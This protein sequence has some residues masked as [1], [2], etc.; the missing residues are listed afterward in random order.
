MRAK[1][2]ALVLLAGTVLILGASG[3]NA[4]R[5]EASPGPGQA[6]VE[7][8]G[9][10][11][12]YVCRDGRAG[13]YEAF[14]D[15]CRL[16][17]GRLMSVFYAGYDHVSLPTARWPKGGRIDYSVS[18]DEGRTWSA[19]RVLYDGPDDDRDPSIVELPS[20]KLL[21]NFFSLRRKAGPDG[22]AG[23][24]DGL[25]TWLVE[26]SDKGKTWS[27][28]RRVSADYYCSS[29]VRVLPDGRLILGLYRQEGEKAWGAVTVSSDEG[30]TW[31]PAVD[32]PNGGFKLDAETDVIALSDGRLLAVQRE[33]G[34]TMCSSFSS[35]GGRTWSVSRAMGFPGH[36]PYL[37]RT[38]AGI[39]VL[40]H[41]LP[42]TSLHYSFDE[43][44][45]WSG[46]VLV[47]DCVGAYPS[48]VELKD[49]S[50]LIIYYEEGPGSNVRARRFR[51]GP[52]GLEWLA[53]GDDK[54]YRR[55][56]PPV[57]IR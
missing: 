30:R 53:F 40:A 47:D 19:P 27:A 22:A 45:T 14:P 32:I 23:A 44:G 11:F 21:C 5:S 3:S 37:L 35:D 51:V 15:V 41:R 25:G 31:S 57:V 17:D 48:M 6:G 10:E 8:A 29:P 16:S 12:V 36:C 34:T 9:R 18:K 1:T 42:Q 39:I 2:A 56:D 50:V 54:V 52:G 24:W 4:I 20:G 43:G 38:S 7:K 33:P 28:P 49:G 26:S 55:D 13:G 46:N